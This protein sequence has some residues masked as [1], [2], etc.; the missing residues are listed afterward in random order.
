MGQIRRRRSNKSSSSGPST[1]SPHDDSSIVST[2]AESMIDNEK[3]SLLT[4]AP[5]TGAAAPRLPS[6]DDL[7][8]ASLIPAALVVVA[9][10]ITAAGLGMNELAN[11]IVTASIRTLVQLYALGSILSPFFR[12]NQ[13]SL[14]FSYILLFMIP[15][16]SYEAIAR[17]SLSYRGFYLNALIGLSVSVV[18]TTSLA[19]FGILKPTPWYSARHFVPIAGMMLNNSLSAVTLA[20]SPL[21]QEMSGS[22]AFGGSARIELL[23]CLG[24]TTYEAL[25]PVL[26]ATLAQSL[27]PTLQSMNVVGLVAIPG[28]M[29]GQVLGGASPK[30]AARYQILILY[31]IVGS[32]SLS[33][34]V[35]SW[36][37]VQRLVTSRGVLLEEEI[38]VNS[39]PRISNLVSFASLTTSVSEQ[40]TRPNSD[41]SNPV[42]V[43]LR[44]DAPGDAR[45]DNALLD[46]DVAVTFAQESRIL[47]AKFSLYP[48]DIAIVTG[49]SGIG[50]TTLLKYI[51]EL[52]SP[53]PVKNSDAPAMLKLNGMYRHEMSPSQWRKRVTYLPQGR[54]SSLPGTP[55][56]LIEEL[57][58]LSSRTDFDVQIVRDTILSYLTA[59]LLPNVDILD[60]NWNTMSGGESQRVLLAV[61]L[62]TE[63]SV[64]L[65]DE[66]TAALD[67]DSKERVEETLLSVSKKSGDA[68]KPT[69]IVLITHDDEQARRLGTVRWYLQ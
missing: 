59:W 1:S 69:A 10:V 66:P 46:V 60:R 56:E 9:L 44:T 4:N 37:T 50:K 5:R 67:V 11:D 54:A 32:A 38:V 31:L 42:T 28:M 23:I 64:L 48:G 27:S 13:P 40:E 21:L 41:S 36:L 34:G 63:P 8:L 47:R 49:P 20:L 12:S 33:V 2:N 6:A 15:L 51:A 45:Q 39:I 24:A 43:E 16:A 53:R 55:N 26:V 57:S 58:H 14:I 52:S 22:G 29:T 25:R 7:S 17:P 18:A 19:T 3:Y 61:V 68:A 35:T 62:A 65:L 30:R